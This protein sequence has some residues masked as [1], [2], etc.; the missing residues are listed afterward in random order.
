ML[1]KYYQSANAIATLNVKLYLFK[2][3]WNLIIKTKEQIHYLE[4]KLIFGLNY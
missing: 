4:I 2:N 1:K 3:D